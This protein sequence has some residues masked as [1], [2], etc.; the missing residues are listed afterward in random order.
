M[1]HY[2]TVKVVVGAV[3]RKNG[4][5]L[6]VQDRKK[7]ANKKWTIP[8]GRAEV[9]HTIEQCAIREAYEESGFRIKLAKKLFVYHE[10]LDKPVRHAFL[11]K[12]VGGHL[13]FR[14]REIIDAGWFSFKKIQK[15]YRANKI[16]HHWVW[17]AISV[18][19]K[20]KK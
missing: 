1:P 7:V 4:K 16:R 19:E 9:G 14:K 15:M 11:G 5:Y 3:L 17:Q 20:T 8:A 10:S 6:L 12:I 18:V 2:A 13:N